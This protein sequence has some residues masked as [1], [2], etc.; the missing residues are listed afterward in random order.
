VGTYG[1]GK[2]AR[3]SWA[4]YRGPVPAG[5]CVLHR[6]DN[7]ACVNPEHLFLGTQEENMADM[8]AKGRAR[9][10]R[11]ADNGNA[12]L[13]A[14]VVAEIRRRYSKRYGILR[15][16]GR[17][18]GVNPSTIAAIVTGKTWKHERSAA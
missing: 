3:A 14:A 17:E 4:L 6:C 1:T 13:T 9:T 11:G 12:V 15:D 5:L 8:K 18:Y 2:A 16:L 10:H 7:R